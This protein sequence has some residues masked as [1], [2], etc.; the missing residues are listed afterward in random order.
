ME[1]SWILT[2]H[3]FPWP[4]H[5]KGSKM[6]RTN[7]L[8]PAPLIRARKKSLIF[9]AIFHFHIKKQTRLREWKR[10][11]ERHLYGRL[12]W[13][14]F[15]ILNKCFSWFSK[16]FHIS[17]RAFWISQTRFSYNIFCPI[18]FVWIANRQADG[19][20]H[21]CCGKTIEIYEWMSGGNV[22]AHL[23]ILFWSSEYPKWSQTPSELPIDVLNRSIS[24]HDETHTN[25]G[26][27]SPN[28]ILNNSQF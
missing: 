14:S 2:R 4:V 8:R 6:L 15:E 26:R 9:G 20:S 7:L 22:V 10:E 3:N 24:I 13:D 17:L 5:S 11:G 1:F 19:F 25:D 18:R 16:S 27:Y 23:T 21:R 12:T 28:C